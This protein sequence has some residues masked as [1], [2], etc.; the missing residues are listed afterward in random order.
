VGWWLGGGGASR[1][2]SERYVYI[3]GETDVENSAVI[4]AHVVSL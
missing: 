1:W 3:Q 4:D 2:D